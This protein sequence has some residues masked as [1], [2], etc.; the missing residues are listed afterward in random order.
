[1]TVDIMDASDRDNKVII[2]IV[3]VAVLL[4]LIGCC[5]RWRRR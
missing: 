3:L 5:G 2:P 4:I 1:M